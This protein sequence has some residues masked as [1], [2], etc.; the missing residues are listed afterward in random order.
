M[1]I[2]D[3]VISIGGVPISEIAEKYGTPTY[4]YDGEKII[5]NYQTALNYARKYYSNFDFF[6]AI[7]A[8]NNLQ[9]ANLLVKNGAGIDAASVNEI[10]L[11]KALG[12]NGNKIMFSGNFLSDE[13]LKVALESDVLINLDDIS[14]FNRL[15]KI[16]LPEIICF[17]VNPGYGRSNVG[18]YVT[19]AGPNAKFGVH[20]DHVVEAYRLAKQ[21]GIKRFG[22]HMMPGSC[23]LDADYFHNITEMLID[24]ILKVA[25]EL[26]INFE[27]IN[28]GGGL[29]IPYKNNETPLD[30]DATMKGISDIIHNFFTDN[31]LPK[32]KILM[33]PARYFVGNAGYIVGKVHAIKNSYS[34]IIGTDVSMN[35]L[36]RPAMY[37]AY[38][39]IYVDQKESDPREK[40]G[41]CG[42]VCENTDFWCKDRDLPETIDVGDLIVVK[43]AGAYGYSMSYQYN[44]RLRPAEVLVQNNKTVLIRSREKFKDII[45]NMILPYEIQDNVYAILNNL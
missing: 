18:E 35:V 1:K 41:L 37:D 29:G 4:V 10:Y 20:P 45:K 3:D 13:D 31:N 21:S 43:D 9:I 12:L 17:R 11:A 2:R 8:C 38:H 36:A 16:G 28:L 34:K 42:Q 39:H 26:N 23:I 15:K 44:G 22:A 30:I 24:I 33:E 7:K 5:K 32:P 27:F 14:L 6:Y 25:L 19:N 40:L